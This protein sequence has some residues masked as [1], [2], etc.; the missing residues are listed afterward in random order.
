L[1]N[2]LYPCNIL[3]LSFFLTFCSYISFFSVENISCA[4]ERSRSLSV[5]YYMWQTAAK[6]SL[7]FSTTTLLLG[8]P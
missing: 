4:S 3:K 7:I 8:S 1:H 6:R 2:K 5:A